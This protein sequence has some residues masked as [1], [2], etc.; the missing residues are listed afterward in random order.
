LRAGELGEQLSDAG[1]LVVAGVQLA[2]HAQS[3]LAGAVHHLVQGRVALDPLPGIQRL[4]QV[5]ELHGVLPSSWSG[6]RGQ[7]VVAGPSPAASCA[8][9]AR[10]STAVQRLPESMI[11]SFFQ[12]LITRETDSGV[13]RASPARSARESGTSSMMP[14]LPRSCP[15]LSASRSSTVATRCGTVSVP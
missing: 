14:S 10:S 13:E 11:P 8:S 7:R 9:R 2:G 6:G 5:L 3:L 15:S 4:Q 1:R 12:R